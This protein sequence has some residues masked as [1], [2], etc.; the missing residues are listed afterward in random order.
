VKATYT[1]LVEEG[2]AE[3][4]REH[5]MEY[6]CRRVIAIEYGRKGIRCNAVAPGVMTVTAT[7]SGAWKRRSTFNNGG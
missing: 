4:V 1:A 6:S 7:E 5:P 2:W 3:A